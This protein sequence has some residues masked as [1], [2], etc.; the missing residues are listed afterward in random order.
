MVEVMKIM[1][2]SFKRSGAH[3]ATL[4]VPDPAAGH[5]GLTPLR[6]SLGQSLVESLLL[7]PGSWRTQS[8]VCAL[9]RSVFPVPCKFW[10]LYGGVNGGFL[11]EALCYT[12]VCCTQ[13][14][15]LCGRPL[16]EERLEHSKAGLPQSLW[17]LLVC[18]K[19]CLILNLISPLLPSSWASPL[20]LDMGY[21]FF[22]GIQHYPVNSCSAASCNFG[23]LTEE[24]PMSFYKLMVTRGKGQGGGSDLEFWTDMYTLLYLNR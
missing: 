17:S 15:C 3:T 13:S 8:F 14:P 20:S 9:Q 22:G 7:S 24:E 2:T 12:Q 5:R 16:L 18:T 1:E 11:Q 21:L 10:L 23:A 4:S 19:F 6:A